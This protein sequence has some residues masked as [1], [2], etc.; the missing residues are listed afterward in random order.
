MTTNT[1]PQDLSRTLASLQDGDR[2]TVRFDPPVIDAEVGPV[3]DA[4]GAIR[5]IAR[6]LF[7]I[8]ETHR[9]AWRMPLCLDLDQKRLADISLVE[10][11]AEAVARKAAAARGEII[12]PAAP[13]TP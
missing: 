10:T 11:A 13:R 7:L 9:T 8:C 5:R 1:T 6:C 4:R 12:F 3:T 2:V